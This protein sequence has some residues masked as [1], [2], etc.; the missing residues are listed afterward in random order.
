MTEKKNDFLIDLLAF[1]QDGA[2]SIVG[3]DTWKK[4]HPLEISTNKT[5]RARKLAKK[6]IESED[7]RWHFYIGSPGNGKSHLVGLIYKSFIEAGWTCEELNESKTAYK[8]CW[9]RPGDKFSSVWFIQDASSVKNAFLD[10]SD[11]ALDL[12]KELEDASRRGVSVV[13]CANRGILGRV[14]ETSEYRESDNWSNSIPGLLHNQSDELKD[15]NL[16]DK[17]IKLTSEELDAESLTSNKAIIIKDLL[18]TIVNEPRWSACE[19]CSYTKHCPLFANKESFK[20][21]AN[22]NR[23]INLLKHS[24]IL[25]GQIMVFRELLAF[26][27]LIF[28]GAS[29]D[30]LN[31]HPCDW[32]RDRV[33]SK[34]LISLLSKRFYYVMFSSNEP[35]GLE[36]NTN[37]KKQQL[38]KLNKLLEFYKREGVLN[39]TLDS[40]LGTSLPTTEYGINRFLGEDGSVSSLDPVRSGLDNSFLNDWSVD[41]NEINNSIEAIN[42]DFT[43]LEKDAIKFWKETIDFIDKGSF[44]DAS[45]L[46]KLIERW[47]SSFLLR[48]G[49]F[50]KDKTWMKDNLDEYCKILETLLP[51]N[52]RPDS[53]KKSLVKKV[54]KELD[55]ILLDLSDMPADIKGVRI[56]E[57]LVVSGEGIDNHIKIKIENS[58]NPPHLNLT[59]SFGSQQSSDFNLDGLKYV[60]LKGVL[61]KK[62]IGR[63]LPHRL[64]ESILQSR[65][66]SVA[67]SNY[68]R[69]ITDQIDYQINDIDNN[70]VKACSDD[71]SFWIDK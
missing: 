64:F 31:E 6:F 71:G 47:S 54:Q 20:N 9:K 43:F 2:L 26:T 10:N 32:V 62:L 65:S 69:T 33:D 41:S 46:A 37:L 40:F 13:V 25:S 68:T 3:A 70:I 18:N 7:P 15:I 49:G 22:Q 53:E 55:K 56:S 66:R 5:E 21:D 28:A 58:T 16:G 30:Y 42:E 51:A 29:I 52:K 60:W 61:D 27:S 57:S 48:M 23:F 8:Y 67:K 39:S 36:R 38:T 34:N 63:S 45:S 14:M 50:Y 59:C 35:S 44:E 4:E 24:E 17:I 11:E 19:D 12:A 1:Q